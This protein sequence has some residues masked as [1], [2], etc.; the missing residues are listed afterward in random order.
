MKK[1]LFVILI[2]AGCNKPT[3][4]TKV[5]VAGDLH[6]IMMKNQTGASIDLHDLQPGNDL[7]A[8]GAVEGLD[9]EILIMNGEAMI[10]K[11]KAD[12]FAVYRNFE[13]K[14]ALLVYT[15]VSQWQET[16]IPEPM[17]LEQLEDFIA[18]VGERNN[19]AEPIAFKIKGT[20]SHIEW[21]IINGKQ[22]KDGQLHNHQAS[23]YRKL[24]A[25]IEV[26]ALGFFSKNHQGVFTHQGQFTHI[27]FKTGDNTTSGHVDDLSLE[28]NSTLFIPKSH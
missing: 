22:M 25:D 20:A 17:N 10:T 15:H 1:L 28:R 2:L 18:Q 16:D 27:H 24:Q 5:H 14:A 11:T 21:H 7:H 4:L 9:G 12:S 13:D 8:L 6:S 26:E 19:L 23:G 3:S